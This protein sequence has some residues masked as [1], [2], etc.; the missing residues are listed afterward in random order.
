M[1]VYQPEAYNGLSYPHVY[2]YTRDFSVIKHS[3][4]YNL[5]KVLQSVLLIRE[6]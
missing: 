2:M 4:I 3:L 5:T 6:Q 1:R